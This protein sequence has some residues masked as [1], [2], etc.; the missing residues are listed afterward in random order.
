VRLYLH[1]IFKEFHIPCDS[2]DR[3]PFA[4]ASLKLY[5]DLVWK[6]T[7]GNG[8]GLAYLTICSRM[9]TDETIFAQLAQ[10]QP[11]TK[12]EK[13]LLFPQKKVRHRNLSWPR[14]VKYTSNVPTSSQLNIKVNH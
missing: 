3:T 14:W 8:P 10:S 9:F 12:L 1:P 5:H 7:G 6:N 2:S 13:S 4:D 11:L